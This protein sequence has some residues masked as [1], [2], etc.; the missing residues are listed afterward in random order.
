VQKLLGHATIASLRAGACEPLLSITANGEA[1]DHA[2]TRWRGPR[3]AGAA[4][5]PDGFDG[6]HVMKMPLLGLVVLRVRHDITALD[7]NRLL[8]V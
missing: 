1:G 4:R 2:A 6:K 3:L 8:P 5:K 7:I